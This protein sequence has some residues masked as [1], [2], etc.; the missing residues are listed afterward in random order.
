MHRRAAWTEFLYSHRKCVLSPG[1]IVLLDHALIFPLRFDRGV[2][3]KVWGSI[4]STHGCPLDTSEQ[5]AN[6]SLPKA[7]LTC[8]GM[9]LSLDCLPSIS[10]RGGA[11]SSPATTAGL[12]MCL[13]PSPIQSAVDDLQSEALYRLGSGSLGDHLSPDDPSQILPCCCCCCSAS[14]LIRRHK[15]ALHIRKLDLKT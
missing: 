7:W 6:P 1:S 14:L 2:S 10:S 3:P 4:V 15:A 8:Q 13:F 12:A 5:M 11:Y 9:K